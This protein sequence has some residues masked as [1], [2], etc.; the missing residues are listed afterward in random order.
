MGPIDTSRAM[1]PAEVT[2]QK[3]ESGA[4]T[5]RPSRSTKFTARQDTLKASLVRKNKPTP[6]PPKIE[7]PANPAFTLQIGAFLLPK[8]ALRNQKLAKERF[9]KYSVYNNY[10]SRSKYYRVSIGKFITR[11]EA[12][13]ARQQI[14][15]KYPKDYSGCWVNYIA[16]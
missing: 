1:V 8:N 6:R 15:K 13:A 16:K 7:R 9:P 10:Y 4:Q 5:K 2:V 14:I 12:I 3:K 11:R